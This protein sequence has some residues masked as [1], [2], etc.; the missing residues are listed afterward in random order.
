MLFEDLKKQIKMGDGTGSTTAYAPQRK[1]STLVC[2]DIQEG[3]PLGKMD[4]ESLAEFIQG[5]EKVFFIIDQIMTT[6]PAPPDDLIDSFKNGKFPKNVEILEKEYGGLL[7]IAVDL[8]LENEAVSFFKDL[9][10]SKDRDFLE[11]HHDEFLK[12]MLNEMG[13]DN[14]DDLF[15]RFDAVQD[16]L[17]SGIDES[18]VDRMGDEIDLCGGAR[19]ECLKEMEMMFEIMGLEV[20][21]VPQFTY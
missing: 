13:D 9:R 10:S 17:V 21:L 14:Y 16:E 8:D 4:V 20:N 15:N 7:R 12:A 11:K 5:Y 6:D 18:I 19:G 1:S 2:V 3:A